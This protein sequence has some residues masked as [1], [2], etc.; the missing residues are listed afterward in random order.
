V[1]F[2]YIAVEH[3]PDPEKSWREMIAFYHLTGYHMLAGKK[4]EEDL[5][6]IY[7]QQGNLI[8]PSYILVDKS[9]NVVTIHAK[10]PSDEDALYQQIEQLL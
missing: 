8:F 4:L 3:R 2:A 1:D 6:K 9:G 7:A 10:R 5:R